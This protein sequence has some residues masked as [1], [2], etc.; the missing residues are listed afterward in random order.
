MSQI[1]CPFFSV[2][3]PCFNRGELIIGTIQSVLQQT[4]DNF[5]I[6][7]VDDGSTDN[8]AEVVK[9]FIDSRI[10]Y[11]YKKNEE[12]N[13]ARNF[14][15]NQSSGIYIC[16]LDS[17]DQYHSNH[18]QELYHNISVHNNYKVFHTRYQFVDEEWK[19]FKTGPCYHSA[20]YKTELL[21]KNILC[22]NCISVFHETVKSVPFINSRNA[23]V[24]EDH[25]WFIKLLANNLPHFIDLIT[26]N[27]LHHK[28]RSLQNIDPFHLEIGT[29]EMI[30]SC[31]TDPIIQK[32][33]GP[34]INSYYSFRL[35]L[36]ST[37]FMGNRYK[38][39]AMQLLVSAVIF[40]FNVIFRKSFWA[41]IKNLLLR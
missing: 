20:T 19:L 15:I 28:T 16:F 30:N 1:P 14:G 18:L 31:F 12:R 27:V 37:Y 21:N 13:I 3:I 9:S 4:F 7:I 38:R 22:I 29:T 2:V 24:G 25:Y 26:V 33:Y 34:A 10:K 17:D 8:T 40:N 35:L 11:F 23:V 5:E 39:K 41:I 32:A 36:C 6:I